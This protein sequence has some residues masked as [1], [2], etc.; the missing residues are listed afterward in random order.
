MSMNPMIET[1][2]NE[3]GSITTRELATADL[4]LF[5]TI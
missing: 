2:E 3:D 1:I 5:G 4:Y